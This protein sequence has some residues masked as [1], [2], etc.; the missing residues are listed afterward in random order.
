MIGGVT[1]VLLAAFWY[2]VAKTKLGR[3][4]RACEQD[5]KDGGFGRRQCRS[6][7]LDDFCDRRR[8]RRR[9]RHTCI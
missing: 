5:Q 8:A 9:R 6:H 1:A 2:L 4:Q 3:A 7:H